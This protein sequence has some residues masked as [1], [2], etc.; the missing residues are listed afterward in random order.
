MAREIT[1]DDW[2]ARV[3]DEAIIARVGGQAFMRGSRYAQEGRV[4]AVSASAGGDIIMAQVRG[5]GGRAYQTMLHARGSAGTADPTA[6]PRWAGNCSCPV[7]QDCKHTAAVV[8]VA[9]ELALGPQDDGPADWEAELT[10]LLRVK[11][12]PRRGMALEVAVGRAPG[13]YYR[14]ELSL[15]PL[16][17]GRNGWNRKGAAWAQLLGGALDGEVDPAI[18]EPLQEIGRMSREG[19]YYT[20]DRLGLHGVTARFWPALRRA[21]DAGLSLTTAQRGGM[22]VSI[23]TGLRAGVDIRMEDDG[24][25]VIAPALDLTGVEGLMQWPPTAGPAAGEHFEPLGSPVHGFAWTN[26]DSSLVLMPLEPAPGEVLSR[27][28]ADPTQRIVIPAPDVG[29][30]EAEY[31]ASLRRAVPILAVDAGV[32]VPDPAI[33]RPVLRVSID[34]ATHAATTQWLMRYLGA[35]G[36]VL[37]EEAIGELGALLDDAPPAA[38]PD[39]TGPGTEEEAPP[40]AARDLPG[41]QRAAREIITALIPLAHEHGVSWGRQE[42]NGIAT[43]RFI[44]RTVPVLRALDLFDVELAGD[45]PDYREVDDAPL[46]TTDVTE[47][48]GDDPDWFSLR[49]RVRVGGEDVPIER[50]I[51]AVAAG[52]TEVMIDSGA[53]I[54]IDR[55]EIHRLAA[56]MEEGRDLADPH[57]RGTMRVSPYQAG[58]YE[59]LVGLGIPGRAAQR[60]RDGVARLL[61]VTAAA[62]GEEPG[63]GGEAPGGATDGGEA[64]VATDGEGFVDPAA[65]GSGLV[66]V[67]PPAGLRAE[68]RPYQ[69]DGYRWLNLL[70]AVGLGGILADDMGLGKTVQVLAVVQRLV[71]E[72]RA[73]MEVAAAPE[74][75][76]PETAENPAAPAGPVLVVAPTSVVSAWME[77][78]R[79]FCPELRVRALTRTSA[80]RGTTVAEEAADADLLVTS[81]TMVRLGEEEFA[82]TDFAWVVCDEAQF[83]KNHASATYKAVRRLRAPSTVAI[84][85][86][87][88]ENSL[89][90]L[91]SL[92]SISAPGLLPSPDR[93]TAE[94]RRPIE[95]GSASKLAGLRARIRPFMLRRT[96]EQVAA[97]LPSKTE[98]VIDVELPA[99]HRRAYEQRL[100]RER[101]KVLGLLEDD[102]AQSRFTALKSLTTLR[103]MALD[104]ALLED[105][106]GQEGQQA[107]EGADGGRAGADGAHEGRGSGRRT[108]RRARSAKVEALLEQLGPVVAEGHQA[109]VFSQFTRYL[110]MVRSELEASGITTAYLDGSTSDRAGVI[111]SFRSGENQVFLISLKAGGFGLTLT[112]AD[113]VFLLDPWWNPQAE[114]QAVDRAHRIGQD[115]PVM[116]Y[117][118][119]STGTIE[120][121]VMALKAKKAELFERVVE[122]ADAAGGTGPADAT[123][124][125]APGGA[126]AR[127]TAAEIRD[128]IDH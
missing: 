111:E 120:E 26:P 87:P 84:T 115:K 105:R 106:A 83:V 114:E 104:P 82:A 119:V 107:R 4:R 50:L 20:D 53:I 128:L 112:E 28:L 42:F 24:A 39:A 52:A 103:L 47:D 117:R 46:I 61:A 67:P 123:G 2:P 15:L 13:G 8:I 71:E 121:K 94:F 9:R 3:T 73:A 110:G 80:K 127:L 30:F 5:S 1:E 62:N 25:A 41:E 93:F 31:L 35:G 90:D 65:N 75:R 99:A 54:S 27:I 45:V 29:R 14:T 19:F 101:Q 86:T 72:R 63:G 34:G 91:W 78:A 126:Q 69:L 70:R 6:S 11:R 10:R 7:R 32:H 96:K 57:A 109:L 40:R 89:A 12:A 125:G 85:G 102:T 92:L 113:Y 64:G 95:R 23:A 16:I 124:A 97:D 36:E 66:G 22:P 43:A 55:P 58:Y 44:I 98:Q 116:V 88:M 18:L 38:G 68:L 56:L 37:R 48:D 49:V 79:R 118:L 77:Q 108:G 60:W 74:A 81:Y 21:V 17:E 76:A 100:A 33:L 122:G 51:S 59:Q